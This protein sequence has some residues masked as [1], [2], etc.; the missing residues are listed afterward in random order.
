[1]MINP[2][3]L[4]EA[5][6]AHLNRFASR[7]V[8]T[9]LSAGATTMLG[10]CCVLAPPRSRQ[11]G[12]LLR[13][14][15]ERRIAQIS[16]IVMALLLTTGLNASPLLRDDFNGPSLDLSVWTIVAEQGSILVSGGYLQT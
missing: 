3:I 14:V 16:L 11:F 12:L 8:G 6:A 2:L 7:I 10:N 4:L 15:P 1:M 5:V 9:A 13:E